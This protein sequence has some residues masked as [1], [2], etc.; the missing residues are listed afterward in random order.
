MPDYEQLELSCGQDSFSP[1]T[2]GNPSKAHLFQFDKIVLCRG[3]LA[4]PERAE[5]VRD[6]CALYPGAQVTE[7]L[8]VPHNRIGVEEQDPGRRVEQGKRTLVF[9][10]PNTPRNHQAPWQAGRRYR[11]RR[12][13]T[14]AFAI[15]HAERVRG[16]SFF[17]LCVALHRVGCCGCPGAM[18]EPTSNTA[19]EM[20]T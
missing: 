15:K 17:T 6:I 2:V 3:S 11:R 9:A 16:G 4:T 13:L 20:C 19:N 5:F 18:N 7:R 14:L 8:N 10:V 1:P 12:A